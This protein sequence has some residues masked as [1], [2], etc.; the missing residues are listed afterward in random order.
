MMA[1]HGASP[2]PCSASLSDDFVARKVAFDVA[3]PKILRCPS[4]FAIPSQTF[5]M[6][7]AKTLPF[8]FFHAII[9]LSA[10]LTIV[11]LTA[12]IC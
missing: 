8:S 10:I 1:E 4:N 5:S 2:V 11:C 6:Y 3:R 9:F 7:T 12:K